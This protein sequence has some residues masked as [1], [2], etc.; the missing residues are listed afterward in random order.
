MLQRTARLRLA[1]G[2][3]ASL[4]LALPGLASWADARFEAAA[5]GAKAHIESHTSATCVRIHGSDCVLCRFLSST[6]LAS[7]VAAPIATREVVAAVARAGPAVARAAAAR[8]LPQSR[9]PP[10]LS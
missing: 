10:T 1:L 2:A 4:Q 5:S 8:G 3:F 6:A 9:A 7:G